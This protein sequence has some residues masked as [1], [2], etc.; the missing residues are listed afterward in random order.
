MI[1]AHRKNHADGTILVTKTMHPSEFGVIV[2]DDEYRIKAFVEKPMNF[3]SNQI[4][5]GM[6][7][8]HIAD[9]TVVTGVYII[10]KTVLD[11]IPEGNVSIERYFFPLLVSM[12]KTFCHPL[13]GRW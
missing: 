5:A 7:Y 9:F 1:A 10:K 6:V 13:Y 4:N 11:H 8:Q 3:I 2:H 12:G